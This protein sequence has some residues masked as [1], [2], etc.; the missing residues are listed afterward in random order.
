MDESAQRFRSHF[1][2]VIS[3]LSLHAQYEESASRPDFLKKLRMRM[4]L[5]AETFPLAIAA[6][7]QKASPGEPL[8]AL[9]KIVAGVYE[10]RNAWE[11]ELAVGD[12]AI[13]P[14]T[15]A[16]LGQ[17]F[18]EFLSNLY[19]RPLPANAPNRIVAKVS[20]DAAG[21]IALS[22]RDANFTPDGPVEPV[23]LLTSRIILELARSLGGEARFDGR[24]IYD[25]R[26]IF[27][28]RGPGG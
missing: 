1:Q 27:P 22:V 20:A 18:A 11:C 10:P 24:Y 16:T 8:E 26:L 5:M 17:I 7:E 15:L 3:L 25:A 12:I 9:A 4:A 14:P 28:K 2:I 19:S 13:D 21:R 23:D 6:P